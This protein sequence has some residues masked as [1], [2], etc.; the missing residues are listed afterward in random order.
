[1]LDTLN[2][3]A[4]EDSE[5]GITVTLPECVRGNLRVM[6][7]LHHRVVDVMADHGLV[8]WLVYDVEAR[9]KTLS[10]E[11]VGDYV[12]DLVREAKVAA[13]KSAKRNPT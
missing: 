12:T 8:E 1:G 4:R 3:I 13:K 6:R 7:W 9:L 10:F 2:S 5:G 11:I